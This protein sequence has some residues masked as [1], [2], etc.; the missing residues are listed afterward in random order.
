MAYFHPLKIILCGK[1]SSW[2][3]CTNLKNVECRNG[4]ANKQKNVT[5]LGGMVV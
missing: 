5:P 4:V 3:T 1:L 2:E